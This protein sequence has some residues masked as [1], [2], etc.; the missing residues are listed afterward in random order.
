MGFLAKRTSPASTNYLHRAISLSILA[1]FLLQTAV[2]QNREQIN[3]VGV[4]TSTT[5]ALYSK[6]FPAFERLHPGIHLT[7]M[8]SGSEIGIAMMTSGAADFGGTDVAVSDKVLAKAAL[9]QIP[10]VLGAIVP[11]YNLPGLTRPLKFS[12]QALAGIYLGTITK[13]NDPAI[14]DLNPGIPL[15]PAPITV[16]H[17]VDGRGATY[18]W[19]SYLS[20]VSPAWRS[21][22]GYGLSIA[23]PTGKEAEGNPKVARFI[24][25]TPDS[26]GFVQAAYALQYAMTQGMVQNAAGKF[27]SPDPS[28][29][30]AAV[31]TALD[32]TNSHRLSITNAPGPGSYPISSFTWILVSS[33]IEPSVKRQALTEFLRWALTD[34]QT[35]AESSGFAPL[36]NAIVER[37]LKT[38]KDISR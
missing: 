28:A 33:S 27:V 38:I 3:L 14:A 11:V 26:I 13:W 15:P 17:S 12:P 18:I 9:V 2:C 4:G 31:A 25:E 19:S 29:L 37:Q 1:L 22:V 30:T 6:W 34:G 10:V 24:K 36:P 32:K 16:V 20:E 7:Y 21:R 23:W 5:L 8:P 35:Y